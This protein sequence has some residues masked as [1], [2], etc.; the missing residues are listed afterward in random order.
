VTTDKPTVLMRFVRWTIEHSL[1]LPIGA[2]VALV[3]AN[4]DQASYTHVAHAIEF[5]V[6][7]IGMAF[8]FGLAAKE[9][10]EATVPGGALHPWRRAAVPL[11]GAVGGMAGPAL[12]YLALAR[13][14]G[15][16]ALARGWAIPC[17]TDIAFS[18]FVAKAL[19]GRS[20]PALPF[21]LLLAIADDAFGLVI[22]A[23]FY[24]VR[25]VQPV[26]VFVLFG[27]G[28][29]TA[30]LMKRRHVTSFWPYVL[31]G[32]S[33]A[34]AG[35]FLG[36]LHP[37]LAL[38]PIVAFLPHAPRDAGP[39]VDQPKA[40][41][42]LNAFEHYWQN[43][44]RVM[45]FAF[46]LANAGVPIR[47]IGTATWVVLGAILAGKPLG[48]AAAVAAA[49]L[50]GFHLPPRMTWRDVFVAGSTAGIG[51]TVALFFAV[52]AFPDGRTLDEAKLGALLSIGSAG[53]AWLGA[54]L[55]R[56]GHFRVSPAG[57]P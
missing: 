48:I 38:V 53:L 50:A 39:L 46:G 19:F 55:L 5:P 51:F 31:I 18:Y 25:A 20:H 54:T 49:A 9:V 11:V 8:F 32:G 28:I 42:T 6:N 13:W 27:L 47:E 35:L 14:S 37:A 23:I 4:I 22:L 34:W 24:P 45:L 26:I 12:L 41:D 33:L 43:P 2:L 15:D 52:A 29:T 56:T 36:G 16:P 17:A 44:V 21:L 3:W 40:R 30:A 10:V 57:R 7:E 1:L